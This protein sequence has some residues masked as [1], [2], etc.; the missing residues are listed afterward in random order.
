[1]GGL[2]K[3]FISNQQTLDLLQKAPIY[4]S[5]F[6]VILSSFRKYKKPYGLLSE[7]IVEKFNTYVYLINQYIKSP[8]L[9]T[10]NESRSDNITVKTLKRRQLTDIDNMRIISAIQQAF[11]STPKQV[12][13]G[14]ERCAVYVT[15]FEPFTTAQMRN[16][17]QIHNQWN[18]PVIIACVRKLN[19]IKGRDFH[20]S[21]EVVLGQM[22]SLSNFNKNLIP[23]YIQ[24]DSWSLNEIFQWCRPTFEPMLVM[25]D[26]GK[27]SE[28]A[29]QLFFEEEI[30]GGAINVEPEFNIGE[31]EN[32]EQ[33]VAK[34]SI[35]DG[36]G[37]MF[38][39]LTPKS[40]H[41]FYD[42]IMN[43]YRVWNGE[44]IVQFKETKF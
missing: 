42:N 10:L 39:E 30:M 4:E 20:L 33:V 14:K 1:M 3:K 8:E 29:L 36:N 7:S 27:K 43:E 41:N 11:M 9:T 2:N 31:M 34:R 15:S 18:M 26:L 35:E 38:M 5:L 23:A 22:K 13:K 12:S 32:N 16:I 17:E 19:K 44:I 37:S 40:I 24:L 25:T 28:M 6:K 21:D